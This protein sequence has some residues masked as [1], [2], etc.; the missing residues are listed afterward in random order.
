MK[1]TVQELRNNRRVQLRGRRP[2]PKKRK[3]PKM[4]TFSLAVEPATDYPHRIVKLEELHLDLLH[5]KLYSNMKPI[6]LFSGKFLVS[7]GYEEQFKNIAQEHGFKAME[8]IE[9]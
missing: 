7:E 9:T 1:K 5:R 8:L 3:A 4:K 2:A 6:S